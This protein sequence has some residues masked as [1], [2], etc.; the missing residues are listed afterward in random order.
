MQEWLLSP[1]GEL[2]TKRKG[3]QEAFLRLV[4]EN[5]R[6]RVR[7]TGLNFTF[8]R[9]GLRLLLE[10][11]EEIKPFLKSH[12]GLAHF[13]PLIRLSTSSPL[14]GLCL[15]KYLPPRPF[16]FTLY[17]KR[18]SEAGIRSQV[19]SFKKELLTLLSEAA[20][21]R[22]KQ[23]DNYPPERLSWSLEG[24]GS[25]IWLLLNK[26]KAPGGLPVGGGGRVLVLFSGGPDSLL[27]AYLMARRGQE[28]RLVFFDDA[29]PGRK[30]MVFQAARALA[31]FFPRLSVSLIRVE[32]RPFLEALKDL[33]PE[34]ERCLFCK[35]VM[36]SQAETLLK[37]NEVL[38]SGEILGEQASQT[39]PA[40]LFTG[41]GRRL[42][43]PLLGFNKE[44][45]FSFL[46]EAGLSQVANLPLPPCTFAPKRPHTKPTK[47]PFVMRK[48]LQK[49]K[50]P[51]QRERIELKWSV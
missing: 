3:T 30:E 31:Y 18:F 47:S 28:V 29:A 21:E 49:L 13:R 10:G 39:L 6:S 12:I 44:E 51:Y 40:L 38:V 4:V 8:K 36:F 22:L 11:P 5:L 50:K 2:G 34:R 26:E 45:V 17:A 32:F 37:E 41:Q 43:R 23:W 15:E 19:L 46:A 33:V 16:T 25:E 20:W 9:Y 48:I 24:H 42:F 27:A 14:E 7:E 35:A 1:S